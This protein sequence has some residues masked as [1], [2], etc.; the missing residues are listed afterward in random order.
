M[1]QNILFDA[2]VFWCTSGDL[3]VSHFAPNPRRCR[4]PE[5]HAEQPCWGA[6]YDPKSGLQKQRPLQWTESGVPRGCMQVAVNRLHEASGLAWQDAESHART[7]HP[8]S[9]PF[10]AP[11]AFVLHR[12]RQQLMD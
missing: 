3:H 12:G 7:L 5:I 8:Q 9:E 11:K 2:P 6:L 1:V 10:S 4:L